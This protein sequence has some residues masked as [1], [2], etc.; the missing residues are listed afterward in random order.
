MKVYL[1]KWGP[2]YNLRTRRFSHS[3]DFSIFYPIY[4]HSLYFFSIF[5]CNVWP[6][7][8]RKF[9]MLPFHQ[10]SRYLHSDWSSEF[11]LKPSSNLHSMCSW[12]GSG[13][14]FSKV[15]VIFK[16]ISRSNFL[17]AKYHLSKHISFQNDF[18]C[19]NTP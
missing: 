8:R 17:F 7:L 3:L 19:C 10:K 9:K 16:V 6:L 14:S 15:K 2:S 18:C 4:I 13:C 5:Q 12:N 1:H 11:V